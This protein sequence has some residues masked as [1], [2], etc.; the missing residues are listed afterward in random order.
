MRVLI[1]TLGCKLNQCE[2]EAIAD[3][4]ATE[5]FEIVRTDEAADLCIVNTCTVTGKAEQKARR[6]IRKYAVQAHR[7]VVLVTGCYAQLE[8]EALQNLSERVVV[9]SLDEKPSLLGLPNM[10]ANHLVAD[11]D[12][13]Q[14]VRKFVEETGDAK[15][16]T[17]GTPFD[18][19]AA[20]FSFHS[21][22]FLKIQ[23][24][25]DN[26]CAYCRVTIAR[27][28][29]VSLDL[30]EVVR[31]SLVLEQDGFKEIVLTGVNISA[32]RS[33]DVVLAGLLDSLLN[34][35]GPGI[36]LRL[37]SL[38]PDRLDDQLLDMFADSRIQP[39]FHI[40][41]QSGSN[42]VLQRV[43]R[44]YDVSRMEQA[45]ARLR[46][47]KDDPFIAADIITGLPGETNGEFEKTVEFLKSMDISQLHVFPFSPRPLTALHTA[48]DKVPESVRDERAKFLRDL[49][50][51]HFR[52]YL[53]RQIGRDVE[54][55]VEE[56]KG[57]IWSGLTGNYLKI[58]V[59]DTPSWLTRGSLASV[60]LERDARTG[61]PVG[62]FLRTQTPE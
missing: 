12:L 23:D 50:A 55:I 26:S 31:R 20:T 7:P 38:E 9:V 24:G 21:R 16:A 56:Q 36:R 44:H 47:V 40:P 54:L 62:R 10:L 61:M 37:S 48:K 57:G 28:D 5:G 34:H 25:C 2:S 46:Q 58:K 11:L 13:L 27:G 8:K 49:S 33:G 59:L 53:N 60:H 51:I 42:Q 15:L 6:M 39:H 41:I 35:L 32:Y 4:F 3:A 29:A 43:N 52:R 22:A 18:Y 17:A 1:Y 45:V 30:K 19:D 14:S